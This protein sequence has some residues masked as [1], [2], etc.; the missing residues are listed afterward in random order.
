MSLGSMAF[1]FWKGKMESLDARYT[2]VMV[3]IHTDT[4]VSGSKADTHQIHTRYT[5]GLHS[6]GASQV[7]TPKLISR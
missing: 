3:Q 6:L 2:G 1:G 5:A 4:R 7:P